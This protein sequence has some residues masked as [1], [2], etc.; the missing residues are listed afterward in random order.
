MTALLLHSLQ[1]VRTLVLVIGLLLALLQVILILVATSLDTGGQFAQLATLLPPFVRALLGPSVT[2]FLSF[3]GIVSLGYFEPG[4]IFAIIGLAIA[5]GTRIAY[6]VEIG[7]IDLILARP[8][9]RHVAVTR[10][11]LVTLLSLGFVVGLMLTAT[12]IGLQTLAPAAAEKPAAGMIFGLAANL[13]L[14]ALAWSSISLAIASASRR[15]GVAAGIAG[16]SALVMFLLDYVARL[17]EPAH[18][19]AWLSPFA[20]F[21]PLSIVTGAELPVRH[22]VV[23]VGIALGGFAAAYGLFLRRDISR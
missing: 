3:G 16:V 9:A 14:E 21:D 8:L 7:F 1:R 11:V 18:R 6:E 12:W 19:I 4:V 22:V 5:V 2:A 10:A 15:R 20:Y 13:G 23:L 17:W